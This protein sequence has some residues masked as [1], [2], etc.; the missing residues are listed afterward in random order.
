[1]Q[2][3][4]R[5]RKLYLRLFDY[6]FSN[7]AKLRESSFGLQKRG[8]HCSHYFYPELSVPGEWSTQTFVSFSLACN[9]SLTNEIF[10]EWEKFC[11]CVT[12]VEPTTM[13][14]RLFCPQAHLPLSQSSSC[15]SVIPQG[16][17]LAPRDLN[18]RRLTKSE[19][20]YQTVTTCQHHIIL[21]VW[22]TLNLRRYTVHVSGQKML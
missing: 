15:G 18:T 19:S 9:T 1:M 22:P 11:S 2:E 4:H 7:L 21:C 13:C 5:F 20:E 3:F 17:S 16:F 10:C 8:F 14:V 12:V 6:K